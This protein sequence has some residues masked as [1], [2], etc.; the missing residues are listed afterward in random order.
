MLFKPTYQSPR[1]FVYVQV[2]LEQ[3]EWRIRYVVTGKNQHVH[4]GVTWTDVENKE[5]LVKQAGKNLPYVLHFQG[6]GV[7]TRMVEHAPNFKETLLVSGHEEDFYFNSVLF[8]STIAVSFLRVSLVQEFMDYL[9]AQKVFT[10][11][12]HAGPVPLAATLAETVSAQLDFNIELVNG[13]IRKLERNTGEVKRLAAPTGFLST[14]E[15]YVQAIRELTAHQPENY[16]DGLSEDFHAATRSDFKEFTRFVKLGVGMLSFFFFALVGNYFYVNHLNTVAAR[17]ETE[18]AGYGENL[19]L[20]DRLRQEKTRK[21]VLVENSGIQSSR[22][23]SFYLDEL[24]A[25]VPAAIQLDMLETFPLIEA[26]KPKRKVE[27]N[28]QHISI[29]GFS[30]SSKILDDWMEQL[31]QKKWISGVELI[32]YVRI[33]DHKATFNLLVKIN[34]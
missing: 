3:Q 33:N 10:W 2:H 9:I 23:L 4:A 14:D 1:K 19:A 11:S 17:Y 25:S 26:L 30:G 8:K 6:F 16:E 34:P 28:T 27:L 12:L 13:D 31:E 24:G 18:I 7:L 15:A 21:T 20:I 22:Y 32:S 5:E 29:T